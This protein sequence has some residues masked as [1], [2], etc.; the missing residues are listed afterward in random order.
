RRTL[1]PARGR[2]TSTS[3]L[4]CERARGT[5][6]GSTVGKRIGSEPLR[7]DG[8][9]ARTDALA[10]IAAFL[11]LLGVKLGWPE[12]DPVAGLAITLAIVWIAFDASRHVL[13]RLLD[14]V[15]PNIVERITHVVVETDGI[16]QCGRI[17]ARWAGRSLYVTVTVAADGG[18]TL[19]ES[20]AVAE[21][22]HHRIIHELP[23][24]AQVDVHVDPFEVNARDAHAETIDHPP[25]PP[26]EAGH[27]H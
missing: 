6:C 8:Q 2:R 26:D 7:A 22:L 13:A 12:A 21:R 11:G 23:G 5:R 20:H 24:V 9:H 25:V 14:A 4:R 19:T 18:L 3:A 15:D 10:S 27:P 17:Q 1:T 16:M